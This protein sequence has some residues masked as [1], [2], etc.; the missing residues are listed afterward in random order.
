MSLSISAN[1]TSPPA[2]LTQFAE[3]NISFGGGAGKA[4]VDSVSGGDAFE[5]NNTQDYGFQF[6][7]N[8]DSNSNPFT[9]HS[10][11]ESPF[12]GSNGSQ[13]DPV[14]FQSYGIQFGTGDQDNYMKFVF[15]NGTSNAD[16]LNGLQIVLEDNGVVTVNSVYDM[17]VSIRRFTDSF[18]FI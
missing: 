5:S 18:D 14:D 6:G 16:A 4:T 1:H 9:I 13:N 3:N 15:M 8:V 17:P 10:K 11:I 7:I 2:Y 12:F